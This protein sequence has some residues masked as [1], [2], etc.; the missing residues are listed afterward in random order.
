MNISHR[1]HKHVLGNYQPAKNKYLEK[2]KSI[3]YDV[4]LGKRE[5]RV[6][7]NEFTLGGY[8]NKLLATMTSLALAFLTNSALLIDWQTI[9][10]FIEPPLYNSFHRYTG[11]TLLNPRYHSDEIYSYPY[12]TSN[13]WVYE[14]DLK[15][16]L[17]QFIPSNKRFIY[18]TAYAFFIDLFCNPFYYDKI[19]QA[20]LVKQETIDKAKYALENPNNILTEIQMQDALF[21]VGYEVVGNLLNYFWVPKQDIMNTVNDYMANEFKDYY[22]IGF[23]LRYE[24]LDPL[25]DTLS[26]IR[27]AFQIEQDYYRSK[28]FIKYNKTVKWY[29]SSDSEP[30]L[31]QIEAAYPKKVITGVGM[32]SHVRVNSQGYYR[33]IIDSELLGRADELII[34]GGSSFGFIAAL[35]SGKL[36]YFIDGKRSYEE[37]KRMT[38]SRTPRRPEG[39]AIF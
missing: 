23:Q 32:I 12:S 34:S 27:C 24:Y 25:P 2:F 15:P 26:F 9:T 33:A 11:E 7:F 13:S 28:D 19:L 5:V 17:R 21:Q 10:P 37:C 4:I 35:K 16:M 18:R 39:Y 20:N 3:H 38:L 1:A 6:V 22:I 36:S 8:A 30:H 29:V 31:N 14:K